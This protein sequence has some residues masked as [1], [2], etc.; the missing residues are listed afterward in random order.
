[1]GTNHKTFLL[2]NLLL[3]SI[4]SK[5]VKFR[6]KKHANK[7]NFVVIEAKSLRNNNSKIPCFQPSTLQAGIAGL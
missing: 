1:M 3:S 5:K 4:I 7:L 6:I 2:K